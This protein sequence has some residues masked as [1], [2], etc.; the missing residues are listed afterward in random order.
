MQRN[1]CNPKNQLICDSETH[2]IEYEKNYKT[3]PKKGYKKM[4]KT[5]IFK[6]LCFTF[7]PDN[8]E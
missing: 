6:L 5:L 4:A 2:K 3:T 7:V 8:Y 1:Q